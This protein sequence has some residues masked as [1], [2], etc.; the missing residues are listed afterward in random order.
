MKTPFETPQTPQTAPKPSATRI[1]PPETGRALFA[2]MRAQLNEPTGKPVGNVWEF[3]LP[4]IKEDLLATYGPLALIPQER[5][6]S[7]HRR[8]LIYR[9]TPKP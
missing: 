4:L 8:I 5:D 7:G 6:A 3:L 1:V 2:R 9:A